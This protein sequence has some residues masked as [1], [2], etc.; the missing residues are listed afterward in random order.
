[1]A[2]LGAWKTGTVTLEA[3]ARGGEAEMEVIER[4]ES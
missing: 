2:L 1:V 3:A 4:R